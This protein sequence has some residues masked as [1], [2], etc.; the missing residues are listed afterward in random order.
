MNQPTAKWNGTAWAWAI[1]L[2]GCGV[3]GRWLFSDIPNF[4]PFMAVALMA[5]FLFGFRWRTAVV[6]LIGLG[7]TDA[8]IGIYDGVVMAAVYG[9]MLIGCGVGTLLRRFADRA[10]VI[11]FASVAT[12]SLAMSLLFF[13]VTNAAVVWAGWY[14]ANWDGLGQS[15][16][17]GLPFFRYTVLSDLF[18]TS[19]LFGSWF[20][21]H[22]R[23]AFPTAFR[24][25]S[26]SLS[27]RLVQSPR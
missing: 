21:C 6:A 19:L 5:G 18:F 26:R 27:R 25:G 23:A 10:F 13:L 14:P 20:A 12:G 1:G 9:C 16:A 8:V 2:I 7:I 15:Y 4:K 24:A 22:E 11:R 3:V 17:A